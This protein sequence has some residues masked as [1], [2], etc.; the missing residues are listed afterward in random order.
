MVNMMKASEFIGMKVLDKQVNEVGKV[1]ELSLKLKHCLV[2]KIYIS[3]GGTLNK[4]YFAIVENDIAEIGDYVQLN[5]DQDAIEELVM[6]DKLEDIMQEGFHFKDVVGK[7]VISHDAMEIGKIS[8]MLIDPKGCLINK[9]IITT[10]SAFNK[11]TLMISDEDIEAMGDYI[12]LRFKK[13]EIEGL[14]D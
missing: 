12:I 5:L 6:V 4:K 1:S 10:G 7:G 11:K 9:V 14:V 8:D 3:T 13:S 2:E